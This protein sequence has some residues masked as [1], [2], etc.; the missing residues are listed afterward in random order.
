MHHKTVCKTTLSLDRKEF[1]DTTG[2]IV[3]TSSSQAL[4]TGTFDPVPF[5]LALYADEAG[6]MQI[7]KTSE[8]GKVAGIKFRISGN[9]VNLTVTTDNSGKVS[10]TLAPGTYTVTELE[11]PDTI[12]NPAFIFTVAEQIQSYDKY[13]N[14]EE[15]TE[16]ETT[17]GHSGGSF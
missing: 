9:G 11:V 2:C 13:I 5:Y 16:E 17:S 10:Q 4:I 3:W 7:V 14:S 1:T 12:I 6:T 15:E 8:T